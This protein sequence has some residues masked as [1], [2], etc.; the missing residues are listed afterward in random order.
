MKK[1]QTTGRKA[2]PRRTE[3]PMTTA[4]WLLNIGLLIFILGTNLGTRPVTRRRLAM[5]VLLA[6][7]AGILLLSN[8]R[9]GGNDVALDFVGAGAGIALGI[10][11]ALLM[12]LGRRGDGTVASKAGLP[13]ALL[14][15]LVIGGRVA[16]A[17]SA[18][19]WAATGIR[20]FSISNSIT[21]AD[22]W[23]AA[24]VIMAL[25]MV[26]ARVATTFILRRALPPSI[27]AGASLPARN[28]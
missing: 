20:D 3:N 19:G 15:L 26:V 27:N 12:P 17:E 23:T 25:A 5:P 18:T 13:Y 8:V 21:G 1:A 22:A 2:A 11:A 24:F 7:A 4:Q 28:Y 10:L 9:T 16:F 14:W 6:G